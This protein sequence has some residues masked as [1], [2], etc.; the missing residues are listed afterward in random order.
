MTPG[1]RRLKAFADRFEETGAFISALYAAYNWQPLEDAR[2]LFIADLRAALSSEAPNI[3]PSEA[4]AGNPV[5]DEP[6]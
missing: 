6:S 3:S 1:E 2:D 5:E 4:S